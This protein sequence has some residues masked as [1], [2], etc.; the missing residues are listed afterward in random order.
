MTFHL[1]KSPGIVVLII[2]GTKFKKNIKEQRYK[3]KHIS[4][5]RISTK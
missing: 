5:Y 4:I 3:L 1:I 2:K